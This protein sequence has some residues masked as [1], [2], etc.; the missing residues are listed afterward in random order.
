MVFLA[1]VLR[2]S[3]FVVQPVVLLPSAAD[4]FTTVSGSSLKTR[5]M[6][7]EEPSFAEG[8][9]YAIDS[10][11]DALTFSSVLYKRRK[12]SASRLPLTASELP[13]SYAP[14]CS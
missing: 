6:D 14:I 8:L 13:P 4:T 9:L 11:E 3:S 10:L 2:S 12:F 5:P 1:Y 7:K